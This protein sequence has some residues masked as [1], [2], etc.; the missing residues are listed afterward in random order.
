VEDHRAMRR[1]L[2]IATVLGLAVPARM[3]G[4]IYNFAEEAPRLGSYEEFRDSLAR[5][6]QIYSVERPTT[7]KLRFG[8]VGELVGRGLP[9]SANDLDRLNLSGYLLYLRTEDARQNGKYYQQAVEELQPVLRR[10][11]DPKNFLG[12]SNRAT[13]YHQLGQESRA[14]DALSEALVNWPES[15]QEVPKE[16]KVLLESLGWNATKFQAYREAETYLLKLWKLRQREGAGNLSPG[17]DSLFDTKEDR[18]RFVGPDGKYQ[19]GKL[20]AIERAKL[21]KNALAIVEQLVLWQPSDLRLYWLAGELINADGNARGALSI[22]NELV[23]ANYT[24]AEL[25][26]HWRILRDEVRPDNDQSPDMTGPTAGK[27]T[28]PKVEPTSPWPTNPWQLLGVGF[29]AGAVVALLGVWQVR[30]IRRRAAARP[31]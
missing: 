8:L 7:A 10:D 24:P 30:E 29:G 12:W 19:A 9:P 6:K 3:W 1:A 2:V 26:E 27:D 11:R 31:L 20:S 14:Q 15:W 21:P 23:N 17:L 4:G 18:V 16:R 5:V 22:F 25:K 13:A 28:G